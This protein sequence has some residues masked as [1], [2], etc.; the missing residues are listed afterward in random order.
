MQVQLSSPSSSVMITMMIHLKLGPCLC[1]SEEM[2][3]AA[4]EQEALDNE[5]SNGGKGRGMFKKSRKYSQ[6]VL[7]T[8]G[9]SPNGYFL[10]S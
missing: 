5:M 3:K 7:T 10:L 6:Q 2:L 8:R 1:L 9:I 4:K